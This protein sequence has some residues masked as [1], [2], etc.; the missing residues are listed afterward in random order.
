MNELYCDICMSELEFDYDAGLP[1]CRDCQSVPNDLFDN[2][3]SPVDCKQEAELEQEA[4]N[5]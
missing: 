4:T 2:G 5:G 3:T 1:W